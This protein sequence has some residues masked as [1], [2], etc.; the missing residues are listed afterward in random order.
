MTGNYA[1][2][3]T[4]FNEEVRVHMLAGQE[5][6][7]V[8]TEDRRKCVEV[9]GSSKND[10]VRIDIWSKGA[11]NVAGKILRFLHVDGDGFGCLEARS[12][13]GQDK[14]IAIAN[15]DNADDK[16]KPGVRQRAGDNDKAR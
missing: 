3:L 7:L 10:N 1:P 2:L 11:H 8:P 9:R 4:M 14:F 15:L 12:V 13:A 6:Q 16:A 5:F